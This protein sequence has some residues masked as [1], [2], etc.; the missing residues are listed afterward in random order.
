M[1]FID[2]FSITNPIHRLSVLIRI[3]GSSP[4]DILGSDF[5]FVFPCLSFPFL[6]C[7]AY[8]GDIEFHYVSLSNR[9][10]RTYFREGVT[11]RVVR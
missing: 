4:S 6:S 11:T 9:T 5:Y 8:V 3:V 10:R 7:L 2:P 1:R